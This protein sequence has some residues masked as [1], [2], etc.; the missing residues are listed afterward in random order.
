[1]STIMGI[2]ILALAP[3]QLTAQ[4]GP[5]AGQSC[6][7]DDCSLS[8]QLHQVASQQPTLDRWAWMNHD[9]AVARTAA[10]QGQRASAIEIV[11]DIDRSLR[12]NLAQVLIDR[13]P[14][15]VLQLHATLQA[16]VADC[17]GKPLDVLDLSMDP[18]ARTHKPR[19]TVEH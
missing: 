5:T 4:T 15:A 13:G 16:L 11:I 6:E 9:L 10:K 19:K 3:Q 14:E 17:Q 7:L 2:I 18:I 8:G 1:M 12:A